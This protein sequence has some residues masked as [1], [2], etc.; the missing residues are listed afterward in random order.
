MAENWI[1]V[2]YQP[3]IRTANGRV[4]DEE[5]LSRWHDP[6]KGILMP[7]DFIPVLENSN[8][9]YKLDLYVVEQV[10]KKLKT[11]IERRLFVVPTSINLS[12]TDFDLCDIVEE[13]RRR[14]DESGIGRD[15]ITIELTE[16][17]VSRDFEFMKKQIERLQE[18]GFKVWMDD[19][20]RGYSSMDLLQDIHFDL[21]ILQ[22]QDNHHRAH[23]DGHRT[24]HRDRHRGRGDT[25]AD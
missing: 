15:K 17:T 2:Y 12:R 7:D 3:I 1:K 9:I 25:G 18:L 11:Q 19:F 4:C 8:L 13:I 14:V 22:K 16:S 24:G 5:A 21:K 6:V 20:G 23:K 10:L